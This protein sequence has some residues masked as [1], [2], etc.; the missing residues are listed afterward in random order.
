LACWTL[1]GRTVAVSAD[2][3][4]GESSRGLTGGG[5]LLGALGTPRAV[6]LPGSHDAGRSEDAQAGCDGP[7]D[8]GV[9]YQAPN[10]S[11]YIEE[12]G[13]R[14]CRQQYIVNLALDP[15]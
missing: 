13:P 2:G 8:R 14:R 7:D 9:R 3:Q 15:L 10:P 5:M 4:H 6:A 12:P 1:N 11:T